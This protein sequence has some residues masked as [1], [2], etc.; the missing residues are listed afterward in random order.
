MF[1]CEIN[2]VVDKRSRKEI[3]NDYDGFVNKFKPK[4]TTDDCY[5]PKPIYEALINY[6][7]ENVQRLDGFNIVRP[8]WPGGD[9][10]AYDYKS[11]DIVIDN[12]PF[13]IL[14][15]II[16]FYIDYDIK[17]W[18]FAPHLTLFNYSNRQCTMVCTDAKITYENG[19]VVATDFVTNIYD[20]ELWV[21]VNGKLHDILE[22]AKKLAMPKKTIT[23][24]RYPINVT[25]SAEL[26]NYIAK[27]GNDFIIK[28]NDG[29]RINK[30]DCQK[31]KAIFGS[32]ILLS[33]AKAKAKAEVLEFSENE[34][35]IIEEIDNRRK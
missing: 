3:F 30:L 27:A 34:R 17:F 14:S 21:Y 31:Q 25:T 35:K 22:K 11:N 13:S 10:R 23:K 18:L 6:I 5:T 28:R 26:G 12:P 29:V 2:N 19:A 33:S 16:D 4:K 1:N 15:K 9:Y 7:D 8:F 20:K 32:G 24:L